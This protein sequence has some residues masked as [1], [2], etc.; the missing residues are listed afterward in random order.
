[1]SDLNTK[2][3]RKLEAYFD[4][5]G[6]YYLDFSNNSLSDFINETLGIELYSEKYNYGSGSKA[7]RIRAIWDLEPNHLIGKL[8]RESIEYSEDEYLHTPNPFKNKPSDELKSQ[9]L[10]IAHRLESS[11]EQASPHIQPKKKQTS[12]QQNK[13]FQLPPKQSSFKHNSGFHLPP[14]DSGFQTQKKSR[15]EQEKQSSI[16]KNKVFIVHGHDEL[17][18]EQVARFVSQIGLTPVILHEQASSSKTIIEKIE[19]YAEQV[20]FA[21]I[22]YTPCDQG[23]KSGDNVLLPRARQ[24]VVFEHGYFIGK[25]GRENVTAIVKSNLEKPN[26]I[27]GV[28]YETFDENGAWKLSLAKEMKSSGCKVDMNN[29]I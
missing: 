19:Q 25:L 29:I 8:I 10:H 14:Q 7:N 6:G 26:D 9:C 2:E 17:I 13:G 16:T 15:F 3:K 20:C 28:V 21:I 18:K 5:S 27:S 4:M 22:L 11:G 23:S 1:M 12:F 24:N